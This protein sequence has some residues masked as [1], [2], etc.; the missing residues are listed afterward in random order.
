M[1]EQKTEIL[2][3]G[4]GPAG[5]T[6]GIYAV[7]S[8]LK[9]I[10]ISGFQT[11]G[12]LTTT[13]DIE[14]FPGFPDPMPGI[15][16][17]DRMKQQAENL[18]VRIVID[19]VKEVDFSNRPFSVKT[20]GGKTFIAE[21]II[22]ATGASAKKTDIKGEEKFW[23]FGVSACATCD[24]FLSRGKHV[25]VIG[26]GNA[27]VIEALH[28]V[29]LGSPVTLIHRRNTLRAEKVMAERVMSN[30]KIN[31]EW[32]SVVDEIFGDEKPLGVTHIKIKNLKTGA[33]KE[34]EV[35]TIFVAIGYQPNT[36]IFRDKIE[37][38]EN[39]YIVTKH[40]S[41]ETSIEGVFAAGDVANPRY[42]QAI[43]AAAKGAEAALDAAKFLEE[44][45]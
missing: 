22:I 11:G 14:N 31:I 41:T 23:G 28:M 36:E 25:A 42:K 5:Y 7:R 35:N 4:S 34:I 18:G 19:N 44:N 16:L 20:E 12:Q 32:D 30:P 21:T 39:G 27:A 6:A 17:M 40:N 24:G 10:I 45:N 8:G 13:T 26:G 29:N 2:I 38:N 33:T 9:P 3:I 37:L 15:D 43:M 1:S